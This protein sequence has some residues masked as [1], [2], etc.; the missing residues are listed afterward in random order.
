[1]T[2]G[3]DQTVSAQQELK[4]PRCVKDAAVAVT[5]TASSMGAAKGED[6]DDD[7]C[8]IDIGIKDDTK[9]CPEERNCLQVLF[10]SQGAALDNKL[11]AALG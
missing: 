6:S 2:R 1:M 7:W 3:K 4:G 5:G 11:R 8:A 9:Q 10:P